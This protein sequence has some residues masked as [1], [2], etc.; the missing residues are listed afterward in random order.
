MKTNL[1]SNVKIKTTLVHN[2]SKSRI[3]SENCYVFWKQKWY[4]IN[5]I[6]RYSKT[7]TNEEHIILIV[8]TQTEEDVL[9]YSSSKNFDWKQMASD[10]IKL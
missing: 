5:V 4:W 7:S 6:H 9:R 3:V 8:D 10:W 1:L 2:W